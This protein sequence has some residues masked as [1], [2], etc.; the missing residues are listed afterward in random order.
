MPDA[1]DGDGTLWDHL[2]D[3]NIGL[4]DDKFAGAGFLA[5]PTAQ[6]KN[7]QTFAC[8]QYTP[9]KSCG[10]GWIIDPDVANQF[11]NICQCPGIPANRHGMRGSGGGASNSPAASRNSQART[12]ACGIVLGSRRA[13]ATARARPS[14][15]ARAVSA[16]SFCDVLM[17]NLYHLSRP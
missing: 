4:D 15:Y 2:V 8:G 14:S 11:R 7:Q 5:R 13:S 17:G 16:A 3:Q 12:S 6:R 10:C 9:G 1:E